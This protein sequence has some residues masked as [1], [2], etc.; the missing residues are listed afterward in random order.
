MSAVDLPN[1]ALSGLGP[2]MRSVIEA[3]PT[4]P[5]VEDVLA[6]LEAVAEKGDTS[7]RAVLDELDA[8]V[9]KRQTTP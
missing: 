9:T 2:L 6:A 5:T 1:D 8:Q 7:A 4:V 3:S